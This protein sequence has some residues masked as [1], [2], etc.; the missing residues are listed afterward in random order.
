V[1]IPA[2][3]SSVGIAAIQIANLVGAAPIALTRTDGKRPA[4]TKLG[5]AHVVVTG[6]QELA[7]EVKRLTD[8]QRPAE[9]VLRHRRC[10][11]LLPDTQ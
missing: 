6:T 3:S 7:A 11:H 5:A 10:R 9:C 1:L 4:L 2:A 8:G